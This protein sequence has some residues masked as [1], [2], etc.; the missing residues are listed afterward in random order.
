MITL[1]VHFGFGQEVTTLSE[2]AVSK[3]ILHDYIAQA[4]GLAGGAIG[5]V[6]FIVFIIGLL[7]QKS[8][9]RIALWVLVSLQVAVNSLFIIIIFVQCPGHESAIW[10][11]SGKR[12]CWDLHVQAYYGYFQGGKRTRPTLCPLSSDTTDID[13]F[14]RGH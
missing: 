13:S 7:V 9:Q 12:K 10:D 8:S 14:Q 5:R 3:V 2:T 11:D 6:S 4:F 1:A